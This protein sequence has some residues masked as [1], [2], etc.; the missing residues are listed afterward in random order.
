MGHMLWK[1]TDSPEYRPLGE[2]SSTCE[3][4][5]M[6]VQNGNGL[7]DIA[8]VG[9]TWRAALTPAVFAPNPEGQ[10]SGETVAV[11]PSDAA[12]MQTVAWQTATL[13]RRKTQASYLNPRRR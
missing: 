4:A 2:I 3:R 13:W 11:P 5:I 1:R 12:F 7:A 10:P 9:P 6:K 8:A